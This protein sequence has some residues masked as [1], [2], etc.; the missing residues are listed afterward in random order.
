MDLDAFIAPASSVVARGNMKADALRFGSIEAT[1]VNSKLRLQ[2][3]QVFFSDIKAETY[4]GS[5]T[6]DLS[7]ELSGKNTAFKAEARLARID[8]DHLL[9][10]FQNARGMMTGTLEG[11]LKLAGKIEHSLSPLAGI[12]G[13]GHVTVR[14]GQVPSLKLNENLMKLAHFNDL[15]PAKQDPSS[16]S[17]ISTELSL[18]NQRISNSKIDILGYGVN[19]QGSG[20][21]SV[22][23]SYGLDYHGVAEILAKQGF[24]ANTIARLS[25]ATVKDGRLSLPFHVGGTIQN[26]IFSKGKKAE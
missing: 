12:H 16:F 15:G 19:V 20:S 7:F 11:E 25:G 23:G 22:T 13:A 6:A 26:P 1:H 8:M 21:F 14:N 9:A 5:A 17:S 10:A 18:A 3:R 4:G 24:F 2:A